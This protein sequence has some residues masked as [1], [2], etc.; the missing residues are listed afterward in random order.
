L[1][2]DV[3][4][5]VVEFLALMERYRSR[6]LAEPL[7]QVADALV[8]EIGLKEAARASVVSAAAAGR[9]M[10]AIDSLVQ[11]LQRFCEKES[12]A[13]LDVWLKRVT[14]DTRD[15]QSSAGNAVT[16]TTLHASKGLEWPVVFLCGM[17]EDLLPHSGIQGEPQNLEEERRLAYVGITRA[18]ERL[19]LTRSQSRMKRGKPVER[20]PSRFL[21]DI[22][23]E[24]LDEVDLTGM[25]QKEKGKEEVDF[26]A[27][28]R[29]KLKGPAAPAP[30]VA[31][32]PL[33][34]P[35]PLRKT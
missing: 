24:L 17:E 1:P 9:K 20:T 21:E 10:G 29:S 22:P 15:E 4:R 5:K 13:T 31:P 6:F 3:G 11:S 18:R 27:S 14:L 23:K 26:F 12:E 16:L 28:L 8:N 33:P 34:A 2:P 25:P 32:A 35:D 30:G 19:Y 7:W